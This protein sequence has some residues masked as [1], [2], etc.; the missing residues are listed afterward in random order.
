MKMLFTFLPLPI[1]DYMLPCFSKQI[2]GIDCPG[3][4]LQ[5]SVAFLFQGDFVAAWDM[6]PAIFTIIPLLVLYTANFFFTIKY[7]NKIILM[8]VL[9]SVGLI[10]TNYILKFI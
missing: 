6:Y 1:K 9:A 2:Y 8:L 10:L 4:G 3:C 5:R 7:I